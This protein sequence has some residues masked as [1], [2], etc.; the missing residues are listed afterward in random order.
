MARLADKV[1]I[2]TG[3][4]RGIGSATVERFVEE[5]AKVA[6]FDVLKNGFPVAPR[7]SV[8]ADRGGGRDI[9]DRQRGREAR[10]AQPAQGLASATGARISV[11]RGDPWRRD[12]PGS[13]GGGVGPGGARQC[14]GRGRQ[15]HARSRVLLGACCDRSAASAHQEGRA[16]SFRSYSCAPNRRPRCNFEE[17]AR[18]TKRSVSGREAGQKRS[19]RRA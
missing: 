7:F 2:V 19:R 17:R 10:K 11:A 9:P 5:G 12:P 1:A 8:S 3:G 4:S 16:C 18:W 15:G 6:I 13:A 14:A